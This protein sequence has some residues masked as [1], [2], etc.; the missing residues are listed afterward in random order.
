NTPLQRTNQS[1]SIYC[2][3]VVIGATV[4]LLTFLTLNTRRQGMAFLRTVPRCSAAKK[5]RKY[6]PLPVGFLENV[7]KPLVQ[8][9]QVHEREYTS[10]TADGKPAVRQID[11][12]DLNFNDPIAAFKS[13]TLKELIRA[14]VVY[15]LCSIGYI[16][17]NNMKVSS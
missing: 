8:L 7:T 12:L 11:P 1:T 10:T 17:E 5:L 9:V 14:Y 6:L 4:P 13:K 3:S 2:Y 15:Q 16:V